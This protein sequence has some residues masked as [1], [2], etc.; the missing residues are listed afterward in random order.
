[1][2]SSLASAIQ[3]CAIVGITSSITLGKGVQHEL[4]AVTTSLDTA[5]LELRATDT[6]GDTLQAR[7]CP[8]H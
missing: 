6:A 7:Q 8:R 2:H 3:V 5:E 1:M 4:C